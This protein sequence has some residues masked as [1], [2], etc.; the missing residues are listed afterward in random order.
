MAGIDR[1][2]PLSQVSGNS[3]RRVETL[4]QSFEDSPFI[5]TIENRRFDTSRPGILQFD[6]S[7][8]VNPETVF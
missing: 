5:Q 2:N 8:V 6:F 1:Q 7:L 4:L 3:R